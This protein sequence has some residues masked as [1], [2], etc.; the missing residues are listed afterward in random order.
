[1]LSVPA[2]RATHHALLS[3]VSHLKRAKLL[4]IQ[5][6]RNQTTSATM[7]ATYTGNPA[8]RPDDEHAGPAEE[9]DGLVPMRERL[10]EGK[11]ATE[12]SVTMP[13]TIS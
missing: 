10:D 5:I 9:Q 6:S 7:T 11:R 4:S 8:T 3:I 13:R 2:T 12:N 1:M